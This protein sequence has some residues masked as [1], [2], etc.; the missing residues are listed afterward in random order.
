MKKVQLFKK[1]N[2][3]VLHIYI[4]EILY[5]HVHRKDNKLLKIFDYMYVKY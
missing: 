1:K 4:C 2:Y 3:I 5:T